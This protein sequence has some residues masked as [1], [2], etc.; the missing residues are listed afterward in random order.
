MS[1]AQDRFNLGLDPETA[2][3]YH[4]ETPPKE[5]HTVAHFCSMCGP[6]FC[7][8]K[9]TRDV[10]D[11]AATLSDPNLAGLP[12]GAVVAGSPA[13]ALAQ[14]GMAEM[15]KNFKALGEQV[16]VDAEKAKVSNKAL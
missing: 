2:L 4:G 15:S 10:R 8:M 11:C 13:E 7:S 1:Q 16:Y 3:R 9:I 5:A 14:G 12:D 6:K